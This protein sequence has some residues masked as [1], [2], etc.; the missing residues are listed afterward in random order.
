MFRIFQTYCQKIKSVA[1][2]LMSKIFKICR[3]G[4]LK[5]KSVAVGYERIDQSPPELKDTPMPK[6]SVLMFAEDAAQC[7]N[8][9]VSAKLAKKTEGSFRNMLHVTDK[10]YVEKDEWN[11]PVLVHRRDDFS[12][13]KFK[14]LNLSVDRF[15][16]GIK[17]QDKKSEKELDCFVTIGR[18]TVHLWN[19]ADLKDGNIE[20]PIWTFEL[21]G[22]ACIEARLFQDKKTLVGLMQHGPYGWSA[23]TTL[24]TLDLQN[25]RYNELM[26]E[27]GVGRFRTMAVLP[28][29]DS[30]FRVGMVRSVRSSLHDNSEIDIMTLNLEAV[31]VKVS[32]EGNPIQMDGISPVE[33]LDGPIQTSQNRRYAIAGMEPP[34]TESHSN[35]K[36]LDMQNGWQVVATLPRCLD[37]TQPRFVSNFA[38][39]V[40]NEILCVFDTESRAHYN[41]TIRIKALLSSDSSHVFVQDQKDVVKAV[42]IT[43]CQ[44]NIFPGQA[45]AN[46]N[47]VAACEIP[48]RISR[49]GLMFA[50]PMTRE[51]ID[52][53]LQPKK[54]QM[55]VC[56]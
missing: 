6:A 47:N 38:V 48:S 46:G 49:R 22:D 31:R 53:E 24:W 43:R 20:A 2:G 9:S 28:Q 19:C 3:R 8:S 25:Q 54:L 4:F 35:K 18:R 12:S 15:V 41:S 33:S 39:Y 17:V 55:A 34:G 16:D 10:F 56:S 51:Q 21:K 29:L 27:R 26:T 50:H 44:P 1:V 13:Y 23:S 36:V 42:R 5:V 30:R 40:F 52:Q 32:Y 14:N 11:K 7:V 45:A 37:R